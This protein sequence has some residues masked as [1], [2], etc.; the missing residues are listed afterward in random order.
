MERAESKIRAKE[1][2][3]GRWGNAVGAVFIF[4]VLATLASVILYII[5]ILGWI[6]GAILGY[7]LNLS[8]N[9][10]CI[11]LTK[12]DEKVK[13]NDCFVSG[14]VLIKA[15][16]AQ[17]IVGLIVV[18]IPIIIFAIGGVSKSSIIAIIGVIIEF[19]ISIYYT[20]TFFTLPF[21]FIENEEIG[22]IDG[23]RKA[24]YIS[25][26]FKWKYFVFLL[27]FIGWIILAC[28]T[29]GI[30]WLWLTPYMTLSTYLFYKHMV[31]EYQ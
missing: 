4:L 20:L 10:Y 6:L 15:A 8:F 9:K 18:I 2:L 28:I 5:P 27:S 17:F 22:I 13:Y 24:I 12:T 26:G 11:M 14:S 1:L 7:Y 19:I 31:G 30:G 23:I 16:V 29:L 3:N 21:I 25:R